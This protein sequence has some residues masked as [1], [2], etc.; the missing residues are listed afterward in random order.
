MA[1]EKEGF[2]MGVG[3]GYYDRFLQ[4]YQGNTL[5]LAFQEQIVDDLPKEAHDIPVAK[6]ITN[7]GIFISY[8]DR[9]YNYFLLCRS[10]GDCRLL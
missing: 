10:S 5:S 8:H 9:F 1:F 3:G 2:R 7:E 4:A 6:I